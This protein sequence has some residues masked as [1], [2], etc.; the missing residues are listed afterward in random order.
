MRCQLL[1]TFKNIFRGENTALLVKKF[2]GSLPHAILA[3]A[4]L[5]T[6]GCASAAKYTKGALPIGGH[7]GLQVS[8]TTAAG[9]EVEPVI[10]GSDNGG[11]ILATVRQ[12]TTDQDPYPGFSLWLADS[13]GQ[14]IRIRMDTFLADVVPD[15]SRGRLITY[16]NEALAPNAR[17]I[18][19]YDPD[20]SVLWYFTGTITAK[21]PP[22]VPF[23]VDTSFRRTYTE[24]FQADDM[25]QW[26]SDHYALTVGLNGEGAPE[27]AV[28]VPAGQSR[29]IETPKGIYLFTAINVSTAESSSCDQDADPNVTWLWIR[30][31]ND[32]R[33]LNRLLETY[34]RGVFETVRSGRTGSPQKRPN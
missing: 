1:H 33:L 13:T 27:G 14:A 10:G 21:L 7:P 5:S 2:C 8:I 31:Q 30:I 32:Q 25:C 22:E 26:N 12:I 6:V 34:K 3:I 19:I 24:A 11:Y 4:A 28:Y 16:R 9:T 20:G 29:I 23:K 15:L 18:R 17:Q